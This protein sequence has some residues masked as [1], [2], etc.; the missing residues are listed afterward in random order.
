MIKFRGKT[1]NNFGDTSQNLLQ[2]DANASH[3]DHFATIGEC[4]RRN[5]IRIHMHVSGGCADFCAIFQYA[6][7]CRTNMR[8]VIACPKE[9]R[10]SSNLSTYDLNKPMLVSIVDLVE[11]PEG[12]I[13]SVRDSVSRF[14]MRAVLSMVW[15]QPLD[16]C[17][18]FREEVANHA[19]AVSTSHSFEVMNE[20]FRPPMHLF[21]GTPE[22]KY[23]KLGIACG[24]VGI[25]QSKSIDQTVQS[26]P[27]IVGN[28]SDVNTPLGR[29]WQTVYAHAKDVFLRL[30]IELRPD[31]LITG[32]SLER[33]LSQSESL[34][35]RFCTS[36]LEARAKQRIFC[37]SKGITYF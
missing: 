34:D 20:F 13:V 27:E 2:H 29:R 11:P 25:L 35:F 33:F 3:S 8:P 37:L 10:T 24:C 16:E 28:F 7:K 9:T 31:D 14:E 23:R 1:L 36:Y 17:L 26:R 12:T 32:I 4:Y 30:R 15:L 19:T 21:R 5:D 22:F 18:M 6:G